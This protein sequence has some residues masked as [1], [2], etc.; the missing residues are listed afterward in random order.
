MN[1]ISL[2]FT[3]KFPQINGQQYPNRYKNG[4]TA[5]QEIT[6]GI[7]NM[8]MSSNTKDF[9]QVLLSRPDG[10]EHEHYAQNKPWQAFK[11]SILQPHRSLSSV[12]F[13]K[14]S[15]EDIMDAQR[16]L[17]ECVLQSIK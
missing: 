16:S 4:V 7:K 17:G 11:E 8:K 12:Q 9:P 5:N 13:V 10:S 3:S 6:Q 15:R 2:N 1:T 14:M